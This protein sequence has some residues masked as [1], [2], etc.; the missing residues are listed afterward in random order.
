[1]SRPRVILLDRILSH[2]GAEANEPRDVLRGVVAGTVD[3]LWLRYR[4][5]NAQLEPKAATT[6]ILY[7]KIQQLS[8]QTDIQRSIK[9][10]ALRNVTGCV[11]KNLVT[12]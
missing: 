1:V 11:V 10:Q 12:L 3:R 7:D 4:S 2:Y 9:A 8:P 5:R 6:E